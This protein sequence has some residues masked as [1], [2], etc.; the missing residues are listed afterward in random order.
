MSS[1]KKAED[2]RSK[3]AIGEMRSF[4]AA[5]QAAQKAVEELEHP[6]QIFEWFGDSVM[7]FCRRLKKHQPY[8][9]EKK[10]NPFGRLQGICQQKTL[11]FLDD[12]DKVA[13]MKAK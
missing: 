1:K 3:T 11:I 6:E 13:G 7:D 8:F 9:Q 12:F 5:S 10:I 4:V 2:L